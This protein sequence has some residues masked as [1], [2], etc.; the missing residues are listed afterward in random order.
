ML[1]LDGRHLLNVQLSELTVPEGLPEATYVG[2]LRHAMNAQY[3]AGAVL[4]HCQ[5]LALK[6][7]Q[8]RN[9]AIR[10]R[11]R[12]PIEGKFFSFQGQSAPYYEVEEL[13]TASRRAYD[14]LRYIL[15]KTFGTDDRSI[16][17]NF[18]KTLAACTKMPDSLRAS[19]EASWLSFG[20]TMTAYR[21]CIQHYAPVTF[22]IETASLEELAGDA[23]SVRIRLPDNPGARSQNAFTFAAGLDAL[24]YGWELANEVFRVATQV[25]ASISTQAV[26]T[27]D[28]ATEQDGP[29]RA[30]GSSVRLPPN[31][32]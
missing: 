4:Y 24:T 2:L 20:T 18:A 8:V 31:G 23:W 6:Y 21:D 28:P 17:S 22:G 9:D 5:E 14:S 26:P 32:R 3:T 29:T 11:Q 10:I 12:L 16:P 13:I 27:A 25:F 15:W 30:V 7:A 19:L 1:S